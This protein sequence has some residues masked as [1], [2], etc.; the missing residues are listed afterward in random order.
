MSNTAERKRRAV[1]SP[2]VSGSTKPRAGASRAANGDRRAYGSRAAVNRRRSSPRGSRAPHPPAATETIDV[3]DGQEDG[4][5]EVVDLTSEAA[6]VSHVVDLTNNDSVLLVDEGL[7]GRRN[8]PAESY[9]VSDDDDVTPL[10]GADVLSS[11]QAQ[12]SARLWRAGVWWCPQSAAT[13]SAASACEMP[14][15]ALSRAPRAA[16][17]SRLDSTTPSTF[18]Q[19]PLCTFFLICKSNKRLCP[20]LCA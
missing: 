7:D 11:L 10:P 3:M 19:H 12:S 15:A 9:V 18:D 13:S 5:E 1:E 17:A 16:N 20:C 8:S 4:I 14:S 2:L 6:E